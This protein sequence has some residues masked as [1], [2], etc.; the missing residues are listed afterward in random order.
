MLSF[1]GNRCGICPAP[2]PPSSFP[3]SSII[4]VDIYLYGGAI[5]VAL[6]KRR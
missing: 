1:P 3:S 6:R 4:D 5:G 2:A